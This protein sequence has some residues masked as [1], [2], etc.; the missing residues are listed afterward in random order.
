MGPGFA[1]EVRSRFDGRWVGGFEVIEI[2]GEEVWVRRRSDGMR[3]P[4]AFG[5]GDIRPPTLD[6]TDPAVAVFSQATAPRG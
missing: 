3:I 5:S 2:T 4:A 6:L 1:V